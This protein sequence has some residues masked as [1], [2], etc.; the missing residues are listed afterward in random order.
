VLALSIF[1][2]RE[3][4]ISLYWQHIYASFIFEL[5]IWLKRS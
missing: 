2:R 4:I 3:E 1:D 5:I